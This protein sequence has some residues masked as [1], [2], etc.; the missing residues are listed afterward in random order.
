ME[1]YFRSAIS[2]SY[3]G[4]FGSARVKLEKRGI[5]I[6]R[7]N[8]HEFVINEYQNSPDKKNKQ[9]GRVLLTF[10]RERNKADYEHSGTFDFSKARRA[11]LKAQQILTQL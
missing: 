7:Q 8:T 4:A 1:A 2:R 3:Y 11:F 10:R 5:N 9:I 6:P